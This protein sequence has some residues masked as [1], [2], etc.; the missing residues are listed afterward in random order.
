MEVSQMFTFIN[1]YITDFI[2]CS[3]MDQIY[4]I[5]EEH[6]VSLSLV[7]GKHVE[8]EMYQRLTYAMLLRL[9]VN[10][11]YFVNH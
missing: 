10:T 5:S 7:T 4:Q 1:D 11:F 8:N 9:N 6:Q 2:L 3:Q